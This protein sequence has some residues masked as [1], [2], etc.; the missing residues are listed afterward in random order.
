MKGVKKWSI[1][2]GISKIGWK[3]TISLSACQN[4]IALSY[5]I[6]DN[7]SGIRQLVLGGDI[8]KR[9]SDHA[10]IVDA[11]QLSDCS[12]FRCALYYQNSRILFPVASPEQI[13]NLS[14]EM[15][16]HYNGIE[17]SLYGQLIGGSSLGQLL[18]AAASMTG[19][20][21][22]YLK[23]AQTLSE[24]SADWEPLLTDKIAGE[25]LRQFKS[26]HFDSPASYITDA[27]SFA[28][29][30]IAKPL[31]TDKNANSFILLHDS[32]GKL[33]PGDVHIFSAVAEL[34]DKAVRFRTERNEEDRHP[35]A[36]WFQRTIS[37][38]KGP[39]ASLSLL[40]QSGWNP[41]DYYQIACVSL[42]VDGE[43]SDLTRSFSDKD[44][45]LVMTEQGL[46]VL[47]HSG[48]NYSLELCDAACAIRQYC[49]KKGFHIG[50]SLPF[51]PIS[52]AKEYY[53]QAL[54]TLSLCKDPSGQSLSTSDMISD[55]ILEKSSS[56]PDTQTY[57][58][59]DIRLLTEMDAR[60][61]EPLLET[62]YTYL[63]LG[64]SASHAAQVL[65]IHRNTLRARLKKI[66]DHLSF[67]IEEYSNL[68]HI[69]I[70]L[71]ITK[72][73]DRS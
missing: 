62:L 42:N 7:D 38:E 31:G 40:E 67:P 51:H 65:F 27:S 22:A 30:I 34:V 68:E 48:K 60:E 20:P 26:Q 4:N 19:F 12:G 58:H 69:L 9:S 50:F 37:E 43:Y 54:Y 29:T 5:Q 39:A 52:L 15:M 66:Q 11:R 28:G 18:D 59:P 21:M 53:I 16:D 56:L 49:I 41:D 25:L 8:K 6:S 3:I 70:S 36:N 55:R 35:L 47:I 63:I 73:P 71:M 33:R 13:L 2:F 45:C 61:N 64:R 44:L 10:C 57:I 1:R 46:S 32:E 23:D 17:A 14:L 72:K 24:R